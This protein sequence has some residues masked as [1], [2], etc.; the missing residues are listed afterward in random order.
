M[1]K[2]E[3]YKWNYVFTDIKP[4]NKDYVYMT[5]LSTNILIK[6][7]DINYYLKKEYQIGY[8]KPYTSCRTQKNF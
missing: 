1:E 6:R 2:K 4:K 3:L 5:N 8:C 7:K